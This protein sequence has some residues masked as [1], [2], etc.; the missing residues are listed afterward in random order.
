LIGSDFRL[1]GLVTLD[2]HDDFLAVAAATAAGEAG[3]LT[4]I[5]SRP[6]EP[7]QVLCRGRVHRAL[8]SW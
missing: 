1:A 6:T 2:V 3:P 5:V 7:G 8:K 4:P